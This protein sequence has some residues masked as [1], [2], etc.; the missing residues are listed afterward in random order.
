MSCPKSL[1]TGGWI[2]TSVQPRC[3][4]VRT[5]CQDMRGQTTEIDRGGK[6][7]RGG[8]AG[9]KE[10]GEEEWER[11]PLA[12]PPDWFELGTPAGIQARTSCRGVWVYVCAHAKRWEGRRTDKSKRERDGRRQRGG[13]QLLAGS[14]SSVCGA[15]CTMKTRCTRKKKKSCRLLLLPS[16][17]KMGLQLPATCG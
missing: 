2:C 1:E 6:K 11:P 12:V 4:R 17:K 14:S 10:R 9:M 16:T 7:E 8:G 3:V 5:C 15:R 13:V